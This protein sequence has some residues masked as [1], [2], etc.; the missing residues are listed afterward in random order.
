MYFTLNQAAKECGRSAGTLSKAVKAGK[1]SVA[2][3]RDDG[4]FKIDPAE[5][6]R[7][8]PKRKET[9]EYER[10]ETSNETS[11]TLREIELLQQMNSQ[12]ADT[13]ADLRKRLDE[14]RD[15]R[16]KLSIMMIEHQNPVQNPKV[17]ELPKEKR[18]WWGKKVQ[19]S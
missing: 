5:L 9:L 8:F 7:V 13:I 11:A 4:S 12:Q 1:L 14:E 16:Q 3:K 18:T 6:F 2:E 19:A 15:E 17:D 10:L